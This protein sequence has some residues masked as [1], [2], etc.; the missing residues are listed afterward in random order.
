MEIRINDTFLFHSS[1][2]MNYKIRI[3][4]INSY[5]EP[6]ERYACDVWDGNGNYAGDVMFFGDDFFETNKDK[7]EKVEE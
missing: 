6:S 1:N 4:N 5:R 3:V 7:I 2:G